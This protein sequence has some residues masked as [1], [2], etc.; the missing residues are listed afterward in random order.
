[1]RIRQYVKPAKH[2]TSKVREANIADANLSDLEKSIFDA[3]RVWRFETARAHNVPAYVI[4]HDATLREIAIEK[5]A[6]LS[7]LKGLSGIGEKKL[8]NYGTA[9]VDVVS[10]YL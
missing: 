2:K 10:N 6:R 9:I 5:P 8:E 1:M 4:F 7:Q 3:L